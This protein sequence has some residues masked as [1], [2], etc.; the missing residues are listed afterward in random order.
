[1]SNEGNEKIS[2][3]QCLEWVWN[4]VASQSE[5]FPYPNLGLEGKNELILLEKRLWYL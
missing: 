3:S 2:H 4:T 5:V 1:M